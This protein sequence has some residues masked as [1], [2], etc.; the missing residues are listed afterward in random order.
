MKKKL[1]FAQSTHL[2]VSI[3]KISANF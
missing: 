3:I 1:I 2:L